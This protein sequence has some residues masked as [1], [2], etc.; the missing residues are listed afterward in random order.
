MTAGFKHDLADGWH[1]SDTFRYRA[2]NATWTVL[3]PSAVTDADKR[4]AGL[5]DA[6]S[7]F[8]G[9]TSWQLRY[10]NDPSQQFSSAMTGNNY[11]TDASLRAVWMN[12]H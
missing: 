3:S 5:G 9:A 12:E 1:L 4:L 7:M 8:A 11:V 10:A 2:M 6:G